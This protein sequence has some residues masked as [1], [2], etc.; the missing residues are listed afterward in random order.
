MNFRKPCT[1]VIPF[2]ILVCCTAASQAAPAGAPAGRAVS[3]NQTYACYMYTPFDIINTNISFQPEGELSFDRWGG[4]GFYV[5]VANVFGGFYWAVDTTL[6]STMTGD[7]NIFMA[8]STAGPFIYGAGVIIF[9]Y[10]TP[11]GFGFVGMR[12]SSP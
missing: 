11:Y 3:D 8:G 2:V 10:E 4:N 7:I 1:S 5:S 12:K 9:E 6:S